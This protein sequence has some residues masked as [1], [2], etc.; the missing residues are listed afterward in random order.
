MGQIGNLQ[1]EETIS[2]RLL[3]SRRE[4]NITWTLTEVFGL[5]FTIIMQYDSFH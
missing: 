3:E 5:L 1:P 2:C 4:I